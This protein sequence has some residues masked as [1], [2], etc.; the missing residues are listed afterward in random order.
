M[1]KSKCP[2]CNSKEFILINVYRVNSY[3]GN[4][5]L[6]TENY[7]SSRGLYDVQTRAL[8]MP[9]NKRLMVEVNQIPIYSYM[10]CNNCDHCERN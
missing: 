7:H 9:E 3:N 5:C 6:Y 8:E 1:T 4:Q 2:R 10:S